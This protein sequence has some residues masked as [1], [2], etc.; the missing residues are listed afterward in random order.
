MAT[1][2]LVSRSSLSTHHL[3]IPHSLC[4]MAYHEIQTPFPTIQIQHA[5]NS[6]HLYSTFSPIIP[7]PNLCIVLK[8]IICWSP[9]TIIMI[10][11]LGLS[12]SPC[13]FTENYQKYYLKDSSQLEIISLYW[14]CN[15]YAPPIMQLHSL[16]C[17]TI[18]S[19][20]FVSLNLFTGYQNISHPRTF[21]LA[22]SSA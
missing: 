6:R 15:W 19:G 5:L 21:T 12:K 2:Y 10:S 7:L 18:I 8:I 16:S 1:I 13:L 11:S 14:E 4:S 3:F 9:R 17:V 20:S 22:I